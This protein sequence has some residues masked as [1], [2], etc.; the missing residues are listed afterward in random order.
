[1]TEGTPESTRTRRM[2]VGALFVSG[3]VWGTTWIPLKHFAG[4]GLGGIDATLRSYG[5]VG[6]LSLP[7]IWRERAA[8]KPQRAL[9]VLAALAGGAANVCFVS[10]MM[11]GNVVRVMLLFYL[12]PVWA[13]LGGRLFLGER[14][15]LPRAL[16]VVT[17]VSGAGL[18]LGGPRLLDAPVSA[19]DLLGLGSGLFYATQNVV[20]R[21]AHRVPVLTKALSIFVGCTLVS[22]VVSLL[23]TT[24]APAITF[25]LAIEL[26]VFAALWIGAAMWT[27]M[28]GVTH[29]EAGRAAVLLVFELV[30]AIVSAMVIRH[31]HLSPLEWVGACMIV[32]A[33]LIDAR[34]DP[35]KQPAG[36]DQPADGQHF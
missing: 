35:G 25:L 30:A 7:F 6:V 13:V 21:A 11:L 14:I 36:G 15:S 17:A 26:L 20:F 29:L 8:W 28:Y 2:A 3:I 12:T 32:A 10:G 24:G 27:T 4:A 31:E 22:G 19:A 9:L 23:R 33:A 1:M 18:V 34:S 16:G 5:W